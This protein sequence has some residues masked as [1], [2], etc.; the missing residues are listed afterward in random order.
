MPATTPQTV[1]DL[2]VTLVEGAPSHKDHTSVVHAYLKQ[3]AT[4]INDAIT[5]AVGPAYANVVR[6]V[7]V[8]SLTT[9][10]QAE[11]DALATKDGS[12]LYVVRP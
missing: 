6:S 2:P 7:E 12:T 5:E 4:D 9:H 11:Y 1:T 8:S 10:T 3:I